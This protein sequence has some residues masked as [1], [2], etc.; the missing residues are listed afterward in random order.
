MRTADMTKM[1]RPKRLIFHQ[2]DFDF[3]DW[4][5]VTMD[6][7]TPVIQDGIASI[8]KEVDDWHL[9][10]WSSGLGYHFLIGNG[11]GIPDGY[12]AIGRRMDFMGAHARKHN[13]DSVGILVVGD[14]GKHDPTEKQLIAASGLCATLC[15]MFGLDPMGDY[16]RIHYLK[17][18]K[19]K[20]I[21]GH[22]DWPPHETRNCPASLKKYF[23]E[24]RIEAEGL[25]FSRMLSLP[26]TP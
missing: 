6:D 15:F 22:S 1:G 26:Y 23:D 4:P 9:K 12:T 21:S 17:R 2:A 10:K 20:V 19:G 16:S 24:I 14:L 3:D 18:Q 5:I 13:H 8:V 11:H 7:P 25:L